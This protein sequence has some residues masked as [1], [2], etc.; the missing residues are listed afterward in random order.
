MLYIR[1]DAAPAGY[2]HGGYW[3]GVR[4]ER[5]I[6]RKC[7]TSITPGMD[8]A[9]R[10]VAK[11]LSSMDERQEAV[12]VCKPQQCWSAW[13]AS[14][15]EGCTPTSCQSAFKTAASSRATNTPSAAP[16]INRAPNCGLEV[17]DVMAGLQSFRM[18][19]QIAGTCL[20]LKII[21]RLTIS[22]V[23]VHA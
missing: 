13:T 12:G 10:H 11:H 15:V 3:K 21:T 20:L 19:S 9:G 18:H 8:C 4:T 2:H 16:M 1:R 14:Q 17:F 7:V 23:R 5:C 22:H 6:S